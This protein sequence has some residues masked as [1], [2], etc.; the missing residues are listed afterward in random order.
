MATPSPRK[1]TI[2]SSFASMFKKRQMEQQQE[3]E[4]QDL[5]GQEGAAAPGASVPSTVSWLAS[6]GKKPITVTAEDDTESVATSDEAADQAKKEYRFLLPPI[7]RRK[8][9]KARPFYRRGSEDQIRREWLSTRKVLTDGWKRKRRDAL[10]RVKRWQQSTGQFRA[11]EQLYF[12]E[13]H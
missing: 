8:I 12:E 3:E 1:W 13:Q 7:D 6:L 11:A 4:E 5:E 2:N 10:R 9:P